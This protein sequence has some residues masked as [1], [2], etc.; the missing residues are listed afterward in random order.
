MAHFLMLIMSQGG[1]RY[2]HVNACGPS[3]ATWVLSNLNPINHYSCPTDLYICR[4]KPF[5][6]MFIEDGPRRNDDECS[7][8]R[9]RQPDP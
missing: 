2:D 8:G 5:L 4:R 9:A 7:Q 6:W 3:K 1:C